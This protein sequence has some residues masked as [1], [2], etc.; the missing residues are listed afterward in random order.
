MNQTANTPYLAE[1][2]KHFH[3]QPCDYYN[4]ITENF[5]KMVQRFPCIKCTD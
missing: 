5:F 4:D 3:N 1:T 2:L